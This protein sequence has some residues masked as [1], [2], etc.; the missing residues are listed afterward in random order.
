MCIFTNHYS[1]E[2]YATKWFF[3]PNMLKTSV[4]FNLL[5][6]SISDLKISKRIVTRHCL[7]TTFC[8][9]DKKIV[10]CCFYILKIKTKNRIMHSS[11]W[12]YMYCTTGNNLFSFFFFFWPNSTVHC[13]F[14]SNKLTLSVLAWT[15]N[16]Y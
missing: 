11:F 10:H 16:R 5:F 6:E 15:N 4:M 12:M 9:I 14:L 1:A 3:D 2:K 13:R 7:R 8:S